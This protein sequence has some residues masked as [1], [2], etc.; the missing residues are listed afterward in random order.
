MKKLN[1]TMRV[2]REVVTAADA[3]QFISQYVQAGRHD[4]TFVKCLAYAAGQAFPRTFEVYRHGND[5]LTPSQDSIAVKMCLGPEQ[6]T[7][8]QF[9]RDLDAVIAHDAAWGALPM[10]LCMEVGR[11]Q[12]RCTML[13]DDQTNVLYFVQ[14]QDGRASDY[15][16]RHAEGFIDSVRAQLAMDGGDSR[17]LDSEAVSRA[18]T[19]HAAQGEPVNVLTA[20][21]PQQ[22]GGRDVPEPPEPPAENP[23]NQ[24]EQPEQPERPERPE[25]PAENPENAPGEP[26]AGENVN[27]LVI[28][29]EWDGE[30]ETPVIMTSQTLDDLKAELRALPAGVLQKCASG[31]VKYRRIDMGSPTAETRQTRTKDGKLHTVPAGVY[32]QVWRSY[33]S[34]FIFNTKNDLVWKQ[35]K[36]GAQ[37]IASYRVPAGTGLFETMKD[38]SGNAWVPLFYQTMNPLC[39]HWNIIWDPQGYIAARKA[40]AGVAASPAGNAPET[41]GRGRKSPEQLERERRTFIVNTLL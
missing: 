33:R 35:T 10:S 7:V 14:E 13:F 40:K 18:I 25:Q 9:K 2:R 17:N 23:E 29:G 38:R 20:A 22:P 34:F 37:M 19:A 8:R 5:I 28:A 15:T 41:V 16:S 24:P 30:E 31:P 26:P 21:V 39:A 36:A 3:A 11:E 32:N 27:G 6:T 1:E 12:K 4:S